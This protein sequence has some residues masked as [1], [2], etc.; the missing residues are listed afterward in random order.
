MSLRS[1]EVAG[2]PRAV[3]RRLL[4]AV[5]AEVDEP[6]LAGNGLDPLF[7]LAG[8]SLRAEIQLKTATLRRSPTMQSAVRLR[9]AYCDLFIHWP[10]IP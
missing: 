1:L 3:E 7:F 2:F 6:S 10:E 8:W 9:K 4:G 5:D